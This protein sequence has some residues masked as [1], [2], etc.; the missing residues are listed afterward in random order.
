MKRVFLVCA[1]VFGLLAPAAAQASSIDYNCGTCGDHNTSFDVTYSLLN[2]L[3]NTYQLTITATYQPVG[4]GGP[5][6]TYISAIA[7]KLANLTY[8]NG[9]PALASGPAEDSWFLMAGGLNS[10]GCN[11]SGAGFYCA[12]PTGFGALIGPAGS[13]DTW[14]YTFDLAGQTALPSSIGLTLKVLFTDGDGD[15]VGSLLSDEGTAYSGCTGACTQDVV[16]E[17]ASLVLLGT[18]LRDWCGDPAPDSSAQ[19]AHQQSSFGAALSNPA[20]ARPQLSAS[21]CPPP[22]K[23]SISLSEINSRADNCSGHRRILE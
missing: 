1:V 13:T 11:G 19:V 14:T 10:S 15:K 12:F 20:G 2:P 5:D 4:A 17:P 16:P 3:A 6:F 7:F 9:G 23:R 8:Q 22:K 18:G 21:F